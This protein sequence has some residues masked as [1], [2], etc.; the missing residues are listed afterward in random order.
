MVKNPSANSGDASLIPR[1]RRSPR[2]G[3]RPTP[4]S[5]LAWEIPW[6]EESGSYSL[7]SHKRVGHDLATKQQQSCRNKPLQN[8]GPDFPHLLIKRGEFS[9]IKYAPT[10]LCHETLHESSGDKTAK[11]EPLLSIREGAFKYLPSHFIIQELWGT[12]IG[13]FWTGSVLNSL[14]SSSLIMP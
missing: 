3:C 1:S 8:S 9:K 12:Y 4:S 2:G 13:Y 7:C 5:N 11:R 14:D 10:I 6:T